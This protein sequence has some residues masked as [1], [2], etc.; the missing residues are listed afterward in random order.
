MEDWQI[1]HHIYRLQLTSW[2]SVF[3]IFLLKKCILPADIEAKASMS[4]F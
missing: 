3:N 4:I 1:T 2:F